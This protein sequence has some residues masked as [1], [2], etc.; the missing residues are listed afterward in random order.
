MS[1]SS[2][3]AITSGTAALTA[4]ISVDTAAIKRADKV[5]MNLLRP[6]EF[7]KANAKAAAA[8]LAGGA[9]FAAAT[10]S[11]PSV[12]ER[13][14]VGEGQWEMSVQGE[15]LV[16]RQ[17]QQSVVVRWGDIAAWGLSSK[18]LMITTNADGR[19]IAP[20]SAVP[21]QIVQVIREGLLA[22]KAPKRRIGVGGNVS[23]FS[24]AGMGEK[25]VQGVVVVVGGLVLL[26][27]VAVFAL[28]SLG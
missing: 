3:V 22:T 24:D 11:I 5:R 15:G 8:G 2:F 14:I 4:N 18:D 19:V 12:R 13:L 23:K 21:D 28:F 1:E 9:A 25:I 7:K 10:A 26:F 20:I 27:A 17:G 6:A 16:F